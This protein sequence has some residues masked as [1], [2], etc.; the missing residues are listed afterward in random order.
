M[1]RSLSQFRNI[2]E[3]MESALSDENA[4]FHWTGWEWLLHLSLIY[5]NAVCVPRSTMIVQLRFKEM[6]SN[7]ITEWLP[8]YEWNNIFPVKTPLKTNCTI[9]TVHLRFIDGEY[10]T[11]LRKWLWQSYSNFWQ[12]NS[13]IELINLDFGSTMWMHN[14]A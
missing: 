11:S 5:S 4:K 3:Y 9:A 1:H 13:S 10:S 2:N 12:A 8:A 14:A 7:L 6:H